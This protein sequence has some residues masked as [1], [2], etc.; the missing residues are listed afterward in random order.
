MTVMHMGAHVLKKFAAELEAAKAVEP[1][2]AIDVPSEHERQ[3]VAMDFDELTKKVDQNEIQPRLERPETTLKDSTV[4]ALLAA[5]QTV[6]LAT[7]LV[8]VTPWPLRS[9][10]MY[11]SLC[12][13]SQMLASPRSAPCCARALC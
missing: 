2:H 1:Q 9:R 6:D 10:V 3:S 11:A 8:M 7:D 5:C 4:N 12:I 13:L